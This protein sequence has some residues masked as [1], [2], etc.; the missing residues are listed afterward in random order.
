M[1]YLMAG[2]NTSPPHGL[3]QT[4]TIFVGAGLDR[5]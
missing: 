1:V 4:G 3:H 5:H 2:H